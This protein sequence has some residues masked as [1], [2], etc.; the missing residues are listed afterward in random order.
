MS[1]FLRAK[2]FYKE[3]RLAHTAMKKATTQL[4]QNETDD[5]FDRQKFYRSLDYMLVCEIVYSALRHKPLPVSVCWR[6]K[7]PSTGKHLPVNRVVYTKKEFI[8]PTGTWHHGITVELLY[9]IITRMMPE[10]QLL[11]HKLEDTSPSVLVSLIL[12][13][14]VDATIKARSA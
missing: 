7:Q 3:I 11:A 1:Y 9:D 6:D 8:S 14:G 10:D 13:Q 12:Q 2:T 5:P 4:R